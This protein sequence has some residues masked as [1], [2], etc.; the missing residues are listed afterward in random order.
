[1]PSQSDYEFGNACVELGFVALDRV[2]EG[3]RLAEESAGATSLEQVLLDRKYLTTAQ[4]AMVRLRLKPA[5]GAPQLPAKPPPSSSFER[6]AVAAPTSGA[7]QLPGFQILQKV[8]SGGAGD[9]YSARQI[10]MDRIVA[11]KILPPRLAADSR[12]V[13]RFVREARA[14]AKLSHPNIITVHDVAS[15]QGVHYMVMEFIDG[16]TVDKLLLQRGVLDEATALNIAVQAARALEVGHKAGIVH[17]DVKPAN[18]MIMSDGTVKL[19]D[20]GLA[21]AAGEGAEGKA[22]GTP[23]YISPEQ[24][25]DEPDVDIRSDL[26][27]L[28]ATLY[29]LV[30]GEIPFPASSGREMMQKHV[31]E[32]LTPPRQRRPSVSPEIEQVICRLMEKDRRKR[33]QTP[34]EVVAALESL[35]ARS[36][37]PASA[38]APAPAAKPP[39][40]HGGARPPSAR[41]AAYVQRAARGRGA[42]PAV[43]AFLV[44]LILG[45][46]W[47]FRGKIG[48]AFRRPDPSGTGGPH[49]PK[50][51]PPPPAVGTADFVA[52][53]ELDV[54]DRYAAADREFEDY[55]KINARYDQFR[56]KYRG[57]KWEARCFDSR[58]A[59]LDR[60]EALGKRRLAEIHSKAR[61]FLAL[62]RLR[63]AY[64]EYRT[65]PAVLLDVTAA[66]TA[67][68]EEMT[69]L[70]GRAAEVYARDKAELEERV[71]AGKYEEALQIVAEIEAYAM[72][73][74]LVE[75][76]GRKAAIE[77]KRAEA[78]STAAI[79]VRDRYLAL[80]GR[81]REAYAARRYLDAVKIVKD[82]VFGP[83]ADEEL[84]FVRI[85]GIDYPALKGALAAGQASDETE[86]WERAVALLEAAMGDPATL[87]ESSTAQIMLIDLRNAVVLEL[88]RRQ[89]EAGLDK[90]LKSGERLALTT[91]SGSVGRFERRSP[92]LAWV[93]EGQRVVDLD[94]WK[95][96][97]EPDLVAVAAQGIGSAAAS[98]AF[99]LRCGLLF[100]YSKAAAVLAAKAVDLF[101]RASEGG[102]RGVRVYLSDLAGT[103]KDL[104][105]RQAEER[106]KTARDLVARQQFAAA[107]SILEE[108][109]RLADSRFLKTNRAEI[110]RL[111]GE[112]LDRLGKGSNLA[113]VYKA[114]VDLV[115]GGRIRVTYDFE[116]KDQMDLFE[117]VT[118]G[119]K[120]KGRW[121][122]DRGC[123][124]SA[125]G[126]SLSS[127]VRW[128]TRVK[129][130]VEIEYDLV[131]REEPQNLSTNLYYN[132]D[133][134][135][136]YAVTFGLDLVVGDMEQKMMMPMSCILKH[137]LGFNRE[138]S[139][140]PAEWEELRKKFVGRAVAD[141]KLDRAQKA[142]VRIA[143]TGRKLELA[144]DG[145]AVWEGEDADYTE[146]FILFFADSR[147]QIDN[148]QI[149]FKP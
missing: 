70:A 72:P 51:A 39:T 83:W 71:R 108:L 127:A 104:E 7:L 42:A 60:A 145:R 36:G 25:K 47:V 43:V 38:V 32:A 17:R 132:P 5:G 2:R 84:R 101:R 105:D 136:Y 144:V 82:S 116:S 11:I 106:L 137:P 67:V 92:G 35:K 134:D 120:I 89:F 124:E 16:P 26:Y 143:R 94:P 9:V 130:D 126:A 61:P 103:L 46:L 148:L 100:Y 45:G 1:M 73:N 113:D 135:R 20:L 88:F 21:K 64:D 141:L 23:R 50:G 95:D 15:H 68:K 10:S 142:R 119:G 122:L 99:L 123:L 87:A 8:G 93:V 86:A 55:A 63:E 12:Y 76:A 107:R 131:T 115:D 96:L 30:T 29:H 102:V 52:R 149:V 59:Y 110:E 69:D 80:D 14:A 58:K 62:G 44:V 57:S 128:R 147:A 140:L 129:G 19:C 6:P 56:D 54:V 53:Q 133:H 31:G 41:S 65:F 146:G 111:L 139:K 91:F 13:E 90:L 118:A 33:Y 98:P 28:G 78:G 121:R 74:Q 37:R 112:I 40:E 4:A 81:I 75:L 79:E 77:R 109:S 97:I 117:P 27:S 22:V 18:L 125:A 49:V 24:A 3:L 85:D 114:K 48:E 138:R 34:A 66:G